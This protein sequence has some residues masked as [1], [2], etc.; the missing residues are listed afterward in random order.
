MQSTHVTTKVKLLSVSKDFNRLLAGLA[1]P[2]NFYLT[3]IFQQQTT[4]YHS[5]PDS[6]PVTVLQLEFSLPTLKGTSCGVRLRTRNEQETTIRTEEEIEIEDSG[7]EFY[8]NFQHYRYNHECQTWFEP[9][10]FN[11]FGVT[12]GNRLRFI[13]SISPSRAF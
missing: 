4:P 9:F 10:V 7:H 5:T 11:E 2:A 8:I 13:N 12:F 3:K 1:P 6:Y